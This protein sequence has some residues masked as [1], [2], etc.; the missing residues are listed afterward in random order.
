MRLKICLRFGD[1]GSGSVRGQS[2]PSD[3]DA[4]PT[5]QRR[6]TRQ[7][8]AVD[9]AAEPGGPDEPDAADDASDGS[10]AS[11]DRAPRDG[12]G[13]RTRRRGGA[14]QCGGG[15]RAG[16]LRRRGGATH[17]RGGVGSALVQGIGNAAGSLWSGV[18]TGYRAVRAAL[19]SYQTAY[20]RVAR[21]ASEASSIVAQQGSTLPSAALAALERV[22]GAAS[23]LKTEIDR[24]YQLRPGR[25][26]NDSLSSA[27]LLREL[28]DLESLWGQ[29]RAFVQRQSACA[30]DAASYQVGTLWGTVEAQL[31]AAEQALVS[32]ESIASRLGTTEVQKASLARLRALLRDRLLYARNTLTYPGARNTVATAY[33]MG[34]ARP[35]LERAAEAAA[36]FQQRLDLAT[37]DVAG[38]PLGDPFLAPEL[39]LR[40]LG[41]YSAGRPPETGLPVFQPPQPS[42]FAQSQ[43]APG[44]S[45][46]PGPAPAP[47]QQAELQRRAADERALQVSMQL[48]RQNQQQ[49]LREQ[50][51]RQQQADA[52]AFAQ[53][54]SSAPPWNQDPFAGDAS[55]ASAAPFGGDPAF[56]DPGLGGL[57]SSDWAARPGG[58]SAQGISE[59]SAE[60]AD[61]AAPASSD[62]AEATVA[63]AASVA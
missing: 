39:T 61:G 15:A 46:L 34:S 7:S 25:T 63:P 62:A 21:V 36:V 17:R 50:Q 37:R 43:F 41:Q 52:S 56:S 42:Q 29:V 24:D 33:F 38:G 3:P 13:A 48:E 47:W 45:L 14:N 11:Q 27:N 9:T 40:A 32:A 22:T 12:G 2:A 23:K 35:L 6:A 58:G 53:S 54:A 59:P 1:G 30:A 10:E 28:V 4:N 20:S 31:A 16:V 44:G 57:G 60:S 18:G 55:G 5:R 51:E 19:M 49:Q 26:P 8:R